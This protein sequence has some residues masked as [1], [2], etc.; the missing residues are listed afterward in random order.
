MKKTKIAYY[1]V[2]TLLSL[3]I[4]MGAFF[5]VTA[6]PMAQDSITSLGYPVYVLYIVGWAKILGII[7][8]WQNKVP[9]LR[10]WAYAGLMFDVVGALASHLFSGDPASVYSGAIIGIVLVTASYIL[11]GKTRQQNL[12]KNA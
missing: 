2:T 5:D 12:I 1:V 8:I 4:L 6:A 9:F 3:F 10:E 11:F 7:G